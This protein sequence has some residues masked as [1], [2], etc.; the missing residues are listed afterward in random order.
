MKKELKHVGVLGM[1]WGVRRARP[2]SSRSSSSGRKTAF[3]PTD[4]DGRKVNKLF[5]KRNRKKIRNFLLGNPDK[6]IKDMPIMNKK[7]KSLDKAQ[8][9]I[10][11]K[12]TSNVLATISVISMASLVFMLKHP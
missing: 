10:M 4:S 7:Y 5:G 8:Q 11:R 1:H 9:E 6:F 3:G 12:R 2:Q